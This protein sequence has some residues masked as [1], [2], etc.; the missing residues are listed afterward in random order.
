MLSGV[1]RPPKRALAALSIFFFFFPSPSWDLIASVSE[2][3]PPSLPP[4]LCTVLKAFGEIYQVGVIYLQG[5]F[6]TQNNHEVHFKI[7]PGVPCP[8]DLFEDCL[9]FLPMGEILFVI[10]CIR[11]V[12]S[13][14][15]T[16]SVWAII[17]HEWVQECNYHMYLQ[18]ILYMHIYCTVHVLQYVTN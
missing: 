15:M 1:V 6:P 12:P 3:I 18:H 16:D 8:K 14:C 2:A 5:V 9:L 11:V 10:P 4:S 13:K 7:M 17:H